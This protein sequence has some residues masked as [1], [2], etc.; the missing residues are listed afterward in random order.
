MCIVWFVCAGAQ[1]STQAE[2]CGLLRVKV[3]R[4]APCNARAGERCWRWA[5]GGS[6]ARR[7]WSA[8]PRGPSPGS[9]ASRSPAPRTRAW[10]APARIHL[11]L[12]LPAVWSALIQRDA[13]AHL[14]VLVVGHVPAVRQRGLRALPRLE[15]RDRCVTHTQMWVRLRISTVHNLCAHLIMFSTTIIT[16]YKSTNEERH[17]DE[18]RGR[19]V[20]GAGR[21]VP[22]RV[23]NMEKKMV[24]GLSNTQATWAYLQASLKH[25][26]AVQHS[27]GYKLYNVQCSYSSSD[28]DAYSA[29]V[30]EAGCSAKHKGWRPAGGRAGR[31]GAHFR[32]QGRHASQIGHIKYV[33]LLAHTSPLR[34]DVR[35][36]TRIYYILVLCLYTEYVLPLF[37]FLNAFIFCELSIRKA[38]A[39]LPISR[40]R[41]LDQFNN[42]KRDYYREQKYCTVQVFV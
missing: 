14:L 37:Q 30:L 9:P 39:L 17:G 16:E 6:S 29:R 20:C 13:S 36:F 15:E 32:N 7:R 11:L 2:R 21:G 35:I 8:A 34:A 27:S 31:G 5:R 38:A 26:T 40:L 25:S 24:P 33:S 4:A 3:A 28:H 22:Q 10:R 1:S 19:R 12:L 23:M 42:L 18:T 41:R